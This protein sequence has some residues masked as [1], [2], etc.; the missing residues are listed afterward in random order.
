MK[1]TNQD[2]QSCFSL[3][4]GAG[5]LPERE[6]FFATPILFLAI[7][8]VFQQKR[9]WLMEDIYRKTP[10]KS[11]PLEYCR[12]Y[13]DSNRCVTLVIGSSRM[14]ETMA[15]HCLRRRSRD[16]DLDAGLTCGFL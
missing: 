12:R 8:R 2:A 10:Y 15:K 9:D 7:V 16:F 4:G 5:G 14:S 3:V 11:P 6:Q 1:I 13:T